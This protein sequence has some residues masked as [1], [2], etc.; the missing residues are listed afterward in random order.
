MQVQH[1]ACQ[2]IASER[3][4]CKSPILAC[5]LIHADL[6]CQS[7]LLQRPELQQAERKSASRLDTMESPPGNVGCSID[8]QLHALQLKVKATGTT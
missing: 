7:L 3:S 4:S 2:P 5:I 8:H 1:H 6:A